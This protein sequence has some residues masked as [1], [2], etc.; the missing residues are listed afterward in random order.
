MQIYWI[1]YYIH[2]NPQKHL[3][4]HLEESSMPQNKIEKENW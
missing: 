3:Y 1:P 4:F 2:Y